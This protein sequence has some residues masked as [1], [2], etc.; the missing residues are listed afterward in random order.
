MILWYKTNWLCNLK[1]K[2]VDCAQGLIV[3]LTPTF[4]NK[5]PVTFK[6]SETAFSKNFKVSKNC[7]SALNPRRFLTQV[8]TCM[9]LFIIPSL[10]I[11]VC[12]TCEHSFM[13]FRLNRSFII[14]INYC[15]LSALFSV[16][17]HRRPVLFFSSG[18]LYLSDAP[19]QRTR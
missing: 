15:I 10:M 14:I 4:W 9:Y 6:S 19:G 5:L 16:W 8:L 1:I 11:S 12:C 18:R 13:I 7:I 17:S 3:L 2:Y